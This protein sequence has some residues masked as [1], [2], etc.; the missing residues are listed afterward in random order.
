M[1]APATTPFPSKEILTNLPKREELL[2]RPVFAL[3]GQGEG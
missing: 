1:T 2:L 3:P